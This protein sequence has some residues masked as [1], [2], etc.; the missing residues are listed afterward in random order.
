MQKIFFLTYNKPDHKPFEKKSANLFSSTKY[1][2]S[3]EEFFPY[4]E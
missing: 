2:A 3:I 4:S 1:P